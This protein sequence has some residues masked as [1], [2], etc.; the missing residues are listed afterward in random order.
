MW[1]KE[2]T[3]HG[4]IVGA[5]AALVITSCLR[6]SPCYELEFVKV[7]RVTKGDDG[8]LELVYHTLAETMFHSPGVDLERI[9]HTLELKVLRA[10][11][12]DDGSPDVRATA[13][14]PFQRKVTFDLGNARSVVLTDGRSSQQIWPEAAQ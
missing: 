9:D 5:I 8:K 6:G 3:V 12:K 13:G 14:S 10:Y 7:D 1:K 11:Y 4:A 2:G